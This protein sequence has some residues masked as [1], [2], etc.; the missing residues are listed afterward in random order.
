LRGRAEVGP[1]VYFCGALEKHLRI[2]MVILRKRVA[3]L[4]GAALERFVLQAKR[5]VG[6]MGTVDVLVANSVDLRALNRRFRGIDKATDVLSFPSA[7]DDSGARLAAGEIAVSAD[8]ARDNAKR[9][10]HP[11]A[12]EVKVLT[13]HGI[14]H[15]AGFDHTS[16]NGEM[17]REEA[18]LRAKLK[19][20]VGLIERVEADGAASAIRESRPRQRS[21]MKRRSA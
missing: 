7:R 6:L 16:D 17:A 3:G 13:L 21:G 18:R 20:P 2:A 4:S 19:L 15:L 9:L 14:L 8:L 12:D 5:A 1:P 11:V 10:G